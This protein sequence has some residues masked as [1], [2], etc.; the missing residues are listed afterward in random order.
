MGGDGGRGIVGVTA[1]RFPKASDI[2]EIKAV[3]E[4]GSTVAEA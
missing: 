2:V 3:C 1:G 4:D